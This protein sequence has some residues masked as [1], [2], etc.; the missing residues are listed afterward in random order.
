VLGAITNF[1]LNRWWAFLGQRT[2]LPAQALRYV[3]GSALTLLV[4]QGM[5]WLLV[6]RGAIAAD[7]AWLPAKIITWAAFSYPYQRLLVFA[8]ARR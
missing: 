3:V 7:R 4:L 1:T 5:L 2:P 6:E 8:G